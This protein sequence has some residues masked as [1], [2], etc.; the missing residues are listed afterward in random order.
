MILYLVIEKLSLD[1]LRSAEFGKLCVM[2]EANVKTGK[3]MVKCGI[4]YENIM[5]AFKVITGMIN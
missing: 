2:N 1:S 4:K 3:E 5:K